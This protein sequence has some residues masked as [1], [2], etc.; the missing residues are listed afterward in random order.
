MGLLYSLQLTVPKEIHYSQS[1]RSSSWIHHELFSL[2]SFDSLVCTIYCSY[3]LGY[4]GKMLYY[5]TVD[6]RFRNVNS[7]WVLHEG[8]ESCHRDRGSLNG[9]RER[10]CNDFERTKWRHRLQSNIW[11]HEQQPLF[12]WIGIPHSWVFGGAEYGLGKECESWCP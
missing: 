12:W 6:A 10:I 4:C 9:I 2:I 11:T 7:Y 5:L 8:F 1:R 3:V